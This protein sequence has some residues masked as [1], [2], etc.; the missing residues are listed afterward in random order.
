ML[1]VIHVPDKQKS[2]KITASMQSPHSNFILH[3]AS[4][5]IK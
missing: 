4:G 1:N 2:T 5:L 3:F